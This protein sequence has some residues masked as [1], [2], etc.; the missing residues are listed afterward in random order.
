MKKDRKE[1]LDAISS[2]MSR[3]DM[4]KISAST[5]ITTG[6]G[7]M[8]PNSLF[9]AN[10][11]SNAANPGANDNSKSYLVRQRPSSLDLF[12]A[13]GTGLIWMKGETLFY[14]NPKNRYMRFRK[15]FE[16]SSKPKRAEIRLFADT[17]Y[18]IWI[19]GVEVGFG[20][21]RSD[22]TWTYF[23]VYN[24]TDLLKSGTN[25]IA[26]LGLFH[27]FGTGG[28]QSIMQALL[29]HLEM[30]SLLGKK[31]YIVSDKSWRTSPAN[32]FNRPTPRIHATLGCVEVQDRRLADEKWIESAYNDNDWS[33][34]DYVKPGLVGTVPWYNFV[35]EVLPQRTLTD[36]EVPNVVNRAT[37][38]FVQPTVDMLGGIRPGASGKKDFL[39]LN[40]S[41]FNNNASV[42]TLDLNRTENGFLTIDVTGSA[43]AVIDVLCGELLVKG[44]IPKPGSSRVHT[45]RFFLKEGR[46][47]LKVEFNW[48]AFRYAQLWI[49]T[50][51]SLQIHK[52]VLRNL[53]LPLGE[54][55][56]F[57]CDDDYM[58]KLDAICEHT[59]RLCT[60]D[61]IVDSSSRELQ[62]WIGDA[63]F[64]VR[65]LHHRFNANI[66][67]K[68]LIE[69]VG[70]GI[71]WMG[72]M[73]ARYPT[74]NINIQ[75]IPLYNLHW[76]L[77][78]QDYEFYTGD[79]QLAVEWWTMIQQVLRFF[80]A[81]ER[82]EDGLLEKVP[83]WMMSDSG[84]IG[85]PVL[86]TVNTILN[87]NYYAAVSFALKLAKR[88]DDKQYE[89]FYN[90][91]SI[92]LFKAIREKLWDNSVGAYSDSLDAK[93]N[94]TTLS[95]ATNAFALIFL[96]QKSSTRAKSIIN[97]VFENSNS[98]PIGSGVFN[99]NIV[100]EA[101][102]KHARA[103]IALYLLKD[104]YAK[105][106]KTGATWEH[107]T[108]FE[109]KDGV[110]M[111]HSLSH[112]WGASPLTFFQ[113]FIVGI[114]PLEEAW[115]KVRIEP[116]TTYLNKAEGSIV[117]AKGKIQSSWKK[118]N[119]IFELTV[120]LP[121]KIK[122]LCVLP[123]GT[124]HKIPTGGG[125]FSCKI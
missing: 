6:V 79:K 102:G 45:T 1:N 73:S 100:L 121:P 53:L 112:A 43:G 17:N 76:V 74:G 110:P 33:M 111:S 124:E 95:E 32:E 49:W 23:D 58:N 51:N 81:F 38:D 84:A 28:R 56:H 37:I 82:D 91:R 60:Q 27:G 46:Q 93:N 34:S 62:Q 72:S 59:L 109:Y 40:I 120:I 61:G 41:G 19:N 69:Q 30:E 54:S 78:I 55:G 108:D 16:L 3:R 122:G 11:N 101:L 83:Y 125:K 92:K 13:K 39:P 68:R 21:G 29:V 117:S 14:D 86:G 35:P 75:P 10:S 2:Q 119:G 98:K 15:S 80:T 67:H 116:Q 25:T 70:Q 118:E 87:I 52:A 22:K 103:D 63:R 44:Q 31:E 26:V 104:R 50:Q 47:T 57:T 65:M 97:N 89:R 4:L 123:N 64:V 88:F 42:I 77:A 107:W 18:K 36:L 48:I 66:I 113:N 71:D 24:V 20:P 99:M 96:E 5:L 85:N 9:G 94:K 106:I 114:Y 90:N 8:V 115:S 105:M 12:W 7:M